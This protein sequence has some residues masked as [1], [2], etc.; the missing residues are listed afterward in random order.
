MRDTSCT[1]SFI[2]IPGSD[3]CRSGEK[4]SMV[5]PRRSN[6]GGWS[7]AI[8]SGHFTASRGRADPS[9]SGWKALCE[10]RFRCQ[11]PPRYFLRSKRCQ[12]RQAQPS[13]RKR[14][15]KTPLRRPV[16]PPFQDAPRTTAPA[17]EQSGIGAPLQDRIGSAIRTH[18]PRTARQELAVVDANVWSDR[19]AGPSWSLVDP[20]AIPPARKMLT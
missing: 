10:D 2:E 7:S 16:Q 5:G 15:S 17:L 13:E 8:R 3:S 4:R 9:V 19:D 20:G 6:R 12:T 1:P 11:G 14:G 18:D